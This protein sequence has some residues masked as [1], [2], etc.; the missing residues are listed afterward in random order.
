MVQKDIIVISIAFIQMK[1]FM[2]DT[3]FISHK[4]FVYLE[5]NKIYLQGYIYSWKHF[6]LA[7][8]DKFT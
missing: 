2:I 6:K 5:L 7:S 3:F 4:I 8:T 1:I